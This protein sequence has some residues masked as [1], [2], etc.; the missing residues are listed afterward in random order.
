[1]AT[2]WDVSTS[3]Y[4]NKKFY[5]GS[6]DTRPQGIFF[7]PDGLNFYTIG[8]NTLFIYQYILS[9]PW[10]IPSSVYSGKSLDISKQA[11]APADL[12]FSPDGMKLFLLDYDNKRVILYNLNGKKHTPWDVSSAVY[13]RKYYNLPTP[14]Y[15]CYAMSFSSSGEYMFILQHGY[16]EV[17]KFILSIPWDITTLSYD[18]Y[19][20]FGATPPTYYDYLCFSDDGLNI[21]ALGTDIK[22]IFQF[23]LLQPWDLV[24]FFYSGKFFDPSSQDTYPNSMIFNSNGERLYIIGSNTDTVYQYTLP[25]AEGDFEYVGT[26]TFTYLGTATQSHSKEYLT[27]ASGQFAYSGSADQI[28]S[29]NYLFEGSGVLA[30]S[31]EAV[32]IFGL[33]FVGGGSLA[34]SGE[35]VVTYTRDYISTA[36]GEL[37]YSGEAIFSYLCNFLFTGSGELAYSGTAKQS[38]TRNFSY[39]ADGSF[40]ISGEAVITI[41]FAYSGSGEFTYLGVADCSY[42]VGITFEYVGSGAYAFSGIAIQVYTTDY[43]YIGSGEFIYFGNAVCIYEVEVVVYEYVGS[44]ILSYSGSAIQSFTLYLFSQATLGIIKSNSKSTILESN[45]KLSILKNN[46]KLDIIENESELRIKKNESKLGIERIKSKL[47][48]IE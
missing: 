27:T 14:P 18:S 9:T 40:T 42:E 7:S 24:G 5:I 39:E 12:F 34:Y 16:N 6:E 1:M 29:K 25:V 21:Y 26:G 44:G 17:R 20:K 4:Y 8:Y 43:L 11:K 10:D 41:G 30:F 47:V 46:S 22:S 48:I 31:G 45:S 28:Y 37:V 19:K 32:I 3:I 38:Y 36:V 2:P 15:Y 23:T 13:S 33:A 35:A